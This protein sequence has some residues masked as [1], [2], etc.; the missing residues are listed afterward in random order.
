MFAHVVLVDELNRATPKTQSGLL[1]AMQEHQV[2]VE[3]ESHELPGPFLVVA[4]QNP[5][6]AYEGTFALPL[7]QLDRFLARVS[8][9]YPETEKEFSWLTGGATQVEPASTPGELRSAQEAVR[10]VHASERP[11]RYVVALLAATREHPL[12]EV[13]ASPRAGLLLLGATRARAAMALIM[14][15]AR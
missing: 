2:T 11:A 6:A 4:T 14:S 7:A 10:S 13:G 3:G 15:P 8:L 12:V 5:S 9:G 1:E